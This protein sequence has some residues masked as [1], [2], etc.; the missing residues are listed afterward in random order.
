[1]DRE[2]EVLL[3]KTLPKA[4]RFAELE[5]LLTYPEVVADKMYFLNLE[6]EKRSLEKCIEIRKKLVD[7]VESLDFY[8]EYAQTEGEN[9]ENQ[10][11]NLGEQIQDY[12]RQLEMI[13]VDIVDDDEDARIELFYDKQIEEQINKIVD[14]YCLIAEKLKLTCQCVRDKN[15]VLLVKG[16]GAYSLFKSECGVYRIKINGIKVYFTVVVSAELER[17]PSIDMKDIKFELFHSSGAG[18]Q[19]VNKVETAVRARYIPTGLAVACQDERSQLQNKERA[20]K[21]LLEKIE[22]QQLEESKKKKDLLL[23]S[24]N[25]D[26]NKG[27][28]KRDYDFDKNIV[29]TSNGATLIL[30]ENLEKVILGNY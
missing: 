29:K 12:R 11:Q 3:D 28:F 16:R 23:K 26:K 7:A 21:L 6:K 14:K 19:N 9:L 2:V 8:N 4:K 25:S 13:L 30:S 5:E 24:L 10:L 1:M 27:I 17:E 22:A 20:L 18:G 15:I